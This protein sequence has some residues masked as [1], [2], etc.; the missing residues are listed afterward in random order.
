MNYMTCSRCGLTVRLRAPYLTVKHCPRCIAR[1]R[2]ALP[3]EPA[4]GPCV[5]NDQ[6]PERVDD[7]TSRNSLP[8]SAEDR[9]T[10]T[11]P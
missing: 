6:N 3:M 1:A 7:A 5:R 10:S 11:S 9:T 8:A 2:I 4:E